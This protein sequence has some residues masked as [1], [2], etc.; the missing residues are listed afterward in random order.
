MLPS[1]ALSK[2]VHGVS[3]PNSNSGSCLCHLRNS[4]ITDITII[5]S[6]DLTT[7]VWASPPIAMDGIVTMCCFWE[8]YR[9]VW[10]C[11]YLY[12]A[13]HSFA[14]ECVCKYLYV[15]VPTGCSC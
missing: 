7:L 6:A 5:I 11:E 12:L 9:D 15:D 4:N 2:P 8:V 10:L 1:V 3:G 13:W 14:V